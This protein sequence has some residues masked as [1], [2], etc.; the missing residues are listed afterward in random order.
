MKFNVKDHG[1]RKAGFVHV[2]LG[3]SA[4]TGAL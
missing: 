1:G 2:N 4:G 3:V